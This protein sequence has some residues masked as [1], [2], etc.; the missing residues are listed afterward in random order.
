MHSVANAYIDWPRVAF[1]PDAQI[2]P[3]GREML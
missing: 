1:T 3:P 2:L